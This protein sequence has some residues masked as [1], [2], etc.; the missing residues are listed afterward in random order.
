[1]GLLEQTARRRKRKAKKKAAPK[2]CKKNQVRRRKKCVKRKVVKKT[3]VVV[4]VPPGTPSPAAPPVTTPLTPLPQPPA[5]PPPAP[6]P[7]LYAGTFGA[8][9]A[10]RL[11]WRAGFGPKAG[12]IA[13]ATARGLD[14]TVDLLTSPQ[15]TPAMIGPAPTDNGNPIAPEDFYA[16]DHLYL[17]DRMVRSDQQLVE[18]MALIWHDWIP[19]TREAVGRLDL[20]FQ[21]IDL[22]RTK[23]LGSFRDLL[24]DV[25]QHPA[26]L[27]FLNTIN[28]D[29]LSPNE[30]YA[31]EVMELFSLGA[32]RGAY[33]ETDV[34]QAAKAMTGFRA[35][36]VNMVGWTNFHYD[37]TAHNTSTKT[38]FGHSGNY[39][40]RDL[41]DLCLNNPYHRSFFVLKMWSYFV[42]APP[43]AATQASLEKLYVDSG[44]SIKA[45]VRAIL[46][47]PDFYTGPALVRPPAVMSAG[48]LR[49]LAKGV[50]DA[51]LA[52]YCEGAG[53]R[54]LGPPNVAGWN[55]KA[56]L[57][58]STLFF[59]WRLVYEGLQDRTVPRDG[60]YSLT[61]TPAEALAAALSFWGDPQVR[62][63]TRQ[64]LLD[65]ATTAVPP[66]LT[67][68]NA[69]N[70]R[71]ERQNM[72]RHLIAASPDLQTS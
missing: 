69:R 7:L 27:V 61:E 68:S 31:R 41:V 62:D 60:T 71:A 11:L 57:D 25:T 22:F 8:A 59:R 42:P 45:V 52:Y 3:P 64:I 33:T 29:K 55:D 26:M 4:R 38:I 35:D 63:E 16:H 30:N 37:A 47:H 70:R 36:Y 14:A 32:D 20:C 18:R 6:D 17:L 44:W 72:L 65:A 9:Q 46:R 56:W 48:V 40:W 49:S 67:G 54:L 23:G 53:Q 66:S 28:S 5:Q 12:D 39:D 13:A 1:M 15:G 58:T 24:L 50:D 51:T 43:D 19:V 10:E 34:R 2:H 21:F